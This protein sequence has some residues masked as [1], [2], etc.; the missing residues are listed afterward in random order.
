MYITLRKE[1][2]LGIQGQLTVT[3]GAM[4]QV[5]GASRKFLHLTCRS[6]CPCTIHFTVLTC[7]VTHFVVVYP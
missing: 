6:V 5:P 7:H 1:E 3:R 4:S 2:F